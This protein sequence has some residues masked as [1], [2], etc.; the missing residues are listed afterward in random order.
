MTRTRTSLLACTALAAF[1]AAPA[2]AS[3]DEYTVAGEDLVRINLEICSAESQLAVRGDTGT[4]L[5]FVVSNSRGGQ[6][7]S[8][9]GIDDYLSV[10][11][12]KEGEGCETFGL[13][14]SNLGE[15]ENTFTVVL[16]PVTES[17]P[18][19]EKYIIQPS[20]TQTV[21]FK[22][23][24]TSAQLLARGDGDTDLD[25]I[26]RNSDGAV[27]HENDDLSDETTATLAGLL[28]DCEKFE[29]EVANL[30]EVYNALMVMVS[31]EG[32]S[33]E[34]FSGTAPSTSLASNSTSAVSRVST[35]A[36]ESGP[37]SYNAA[38]NS[39]IRVDL[40][41]CSTSLLEV[42][43]DGDTDLD[44]TITD[45]GG[46]TIH[47]DF[48]L[49]D[50]TYA[51]LS[52][53]DGCETF[54]MAVDN[55]G[56]VYNVFS[57]TLTDVNEQGGVSGS[58]QYRINATSETKML[59]RVCETTRVA[60]R[61]DGDTDLDFDI[62]DS[63]GASV[64]T[65]YD[66]T[67]QTD[68]TLDPGSGCENF[69]MSVSNLGDVYNI[70]TVTYNGEELGPDAAVA[71]PP[72]PIAIA[73]APPPVIPSLPSSGNEVVG[74]GPGEYRADANS[75][76]TV[77]LRLCDVTWV[78]VAGN[79]D[80]DLDFVVRAENGDVIHS[81]YDMTDVTAFSADP[82]RKCSTFQLEVSNLGQ[83]YN[84]FFVSTAN[85]WEDAHAAAEAVAD[86][87]AAAAEAAATETI[88][89]VPED[90]ISP[91][92]ANR[93]IALLNRSGEAL[94]SIQW[95]NSAVVD[96]GENKLGD[97][98]MLASG[99][100]WN[101]NVYDGSAACIFDFKGVTAGGREIAVTQINAC[102]VTSVTFE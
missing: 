6:V 98:G 62:N 27:V 19:I 66:M 95:S 55:L 42:R 64:H 90:T 97:S 102:E 43:G 50:V 15:E 70:L 9:Q 33:E 92:G 71:R 72:S 96:W 76:V 67:D 3:I 34:P 21:D 37:G 5:D 94:T 84:V 8:D 86:A 36:E 2:Q 30:G 28:S 54:A 80:T 48:D 39:S 13:A 77:N 7:H 61:G 1:V 44:F 101:I 68:F 11:I 10:V 83:V 93:N 63:S 41:V 74:S 4:D 12:E 20:A 35:V 40:P 56:D 24:G 29:M 60:A 32:V 49:S 89:D 58:G 82:G 31:P 52:P 26:V 99:Q 81:N 22:A 65:D 14:V 69:Q 16:E 53:S 51:T 75:K 73:P 18:R 59:L 47:S 25:F 85:G 38:A 78:T 87:V 57:V 100:Q 88:V 79:G 23:C 91:D 17:S 46:D 45:E